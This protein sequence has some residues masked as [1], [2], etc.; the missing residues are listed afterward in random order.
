MMYDEAIVQIVCKCIS[1]IIKRIE[2]SKQWDISNIDCFCSI[3][4]MKVLS[5]NFMKSVGFTAGVA[6]P[7]IFDHRT[8]NVKCVVH[9]LVAQDRTISQKHGLPVRGSLSSICI[10]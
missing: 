4:L 7:C 1:I 9:G 2:Q 8:R 10:Q 6:S 5:S 3:N